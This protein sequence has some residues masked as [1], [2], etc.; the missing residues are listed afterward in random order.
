MHGRSGDGCERRSRLPGYGLR[1]AA[2][3]LVAVLGAAVLVGCAQRSDP[4]GSSN[5]AE[6]PPLPGFDQPS[7]TGG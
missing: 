6:I 7:P 5:G 3:L 4:A 1:R 2:A